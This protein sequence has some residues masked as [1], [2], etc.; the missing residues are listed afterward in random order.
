MSGRHFEL[1]A[2]PNLAYYRKQA[3]QLLRAHAAGDGVAWA[4]V[5]EVLGG[6][7]AGRFLLSDAQFV[8]AQEHGFR[9]WAEFRAHVGGSFGDRPVSRLMGVRPGIYAAMAEALL[10]ELRRGDP[11]AVR[12]LRAYVPRHAAATAGGTP[13]T[14]STLSTAAS[15][16]TAGAPS[17]VTVELRDARLIIARELGFPTWRELVSYTEKSRRDLADRR[18]ERRRLRRQAQALLAGDTPRLA[19]LA[20]EQAGILLR[21]LALPEAIPGVRLGREL[22]VPRAAVEVL[23]GKAADLDLPLTWA[24]RF[25]RLAYVRLLLDAG[26]DPGARAEGVFPLENAIY[27]GNT[28]IVDL[29]AGHTIVPRSLWTFAACGRLDLVRAC[30]DANGRLR[31]DAAPTR[32]DLADT[33]AGFPSRLPP[34][35]DPAEIEGEAFVHACQH[36]RVEVVRWF[37]DRGVHPDVA[38]Y[39]GR[40]GLH[41]AIPG[42]RLPVIRLL[43][44]RGAD[45][46]VRDDLLRADAGGWVRIAFAARP[47]DPVARR[48]QYLFESRTR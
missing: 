38:P 45:P 39:L 6:R 10:T 20:T 42:G 26:A 46:S 32:P 36:G 22:G 11:G 28:D 40:T 17:S 16:T 34:S 15:A 19:A 31:P 33:G 44:E 23:L 2:R 14:L 4:R 35:D 8:V 5:G 47:H 7:R 12:R 3:K 29:L 43:L 13:A 41:W 48:L 1:P 25:D 37:L 21:M 30:F 9:S 27:H 18:E 24:A